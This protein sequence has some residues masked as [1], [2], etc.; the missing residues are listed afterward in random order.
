M[1][2]TIERIAV[3][4]LSANCYMVY[5]ESRD[6]CVIV[7]AGAEADRIKR[8]LRGR[9]VAAVLLTH[10]H[11]DH[12]GAVDGLAGD[13]TELYIHTDDLPML[14][15]TALNLSAPFGMPLVIR[16]PAKTFT[17]GSRLS[18]AGL[19]IK[20]I[21]TP[22]H[23]KGSCCFDVSG[24]LLTGD[25]L[26]HMGRGR[27]DFPGGSERELLKSLQMLLSLDDTRFYPGHGESAMLSQEADVL[28]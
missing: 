11:I 28:W 22:G 5:D 12:I 2:V 3:G 25:T 16:K 20:V 14:T 4:E 27:T 6:D 10:G 13:N 18:L 23:T 1:A 26:F 17:G 8:F 19:D 7:D 24:Y 15:D 21:H 9:T